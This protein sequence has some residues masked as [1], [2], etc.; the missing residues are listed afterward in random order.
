MD[1]SKFFATLEP[2]DQLFNESTTRGF[3]AAIACAPNLL[4]AEEWLPYLWGGLDVA[5]FSDA[6]QFEQYCQAV[7]EQWNTTRQQLLAQSWEWPTA[8]HLDEQTFVTQD[9]QDFC[10]GY[11]QGWQ[12]TQDDWQ[13]LVEEHSEDNTLLGG[14]LLAISLLYDPETAITTLEQSGAAELSQF[15]EIYQAIPTM[16]SGLTIKGIA[17]E[18]NA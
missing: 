12:L 11:L 10:E 2:S 9:T 7:V 13:N 6:S 14:V 15:E 3:I 17:L 4:P 16:L 5:P 8:C 18:K 1:L